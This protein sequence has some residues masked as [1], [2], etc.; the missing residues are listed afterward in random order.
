MTL[1]T[2][3]GVCLDG[4]KLA[5]A[6]PRSDNGVRLSADQFRK[7]AR[8]AM[9]GMGDGA[10][11]H[12]HRTESRSGPYGTRPHRTWIGEGGGPLPNSAS[13]KG[14]NPRFCRRRCARTLVTSVSAQM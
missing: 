10:L 14:R 2:I 9:A 4:D 1:F 12:P 11:P 7:Q 6:D 5:I 13:G 3:S 8:T